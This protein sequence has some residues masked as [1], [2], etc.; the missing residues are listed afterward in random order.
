[1]VAGPNGLNC[2]PG[3]TWLPP[4][5]CGWMFLVLAWWVV[6][7]WPGVWLLWGAAVD[8]GSCVASL[9]EWIS[10]CLESLVTGLGH[11]IL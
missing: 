11:H 7:D 8:C 1:M 10:L 3:L 2:G 5:L 6:G 9:A 4:S